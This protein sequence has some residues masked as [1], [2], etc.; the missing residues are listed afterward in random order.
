MSS[1]TMSLFLLL[2]SANSFLVSRSFVLNPSTTGS[3]I[4]IGHA[5]P[6]TSTASITNYMLDNSLTRNIPQSP[7][8]LHATTEREARNETRNANNYDST[9]QKSKKKDF[10]EVSRL[11]FMLNQLKGNM[12][13]S[14]MRAGAA[15]RRVAMLQ[16]QIQDNLQAQGEGQA[17]T[18][19]GGDG[20]ANRATT[21]ATMSAEEKAQQEEMKKENEMFLNQVKS[22]KGTI[23][24]I[25]KAMENFKKETEQKMADMNTANEKERIEWKKQTDALQGELTTANDELKTARKES[26]HLGAEIKA[27]EMHMEIKEQELIEES[28]RKLEEAKSQAQKVQYSLEV[29]KELLKEKLVASKDRTDELLKDL[30]MTKID[31]TQELITV[32]TDAEKQ[33]EKAKKDLDIKAQDISVKKETIKMLVGE[34]QSIRKL[35]RVQR[36]LIKARVKSRI[37]RIMGKS[38]E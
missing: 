28:E 38:E 23:K 5:I 10:T 37:G 8:S 35:F 27:L 18:N 34:R 26:D 14:E 12:Q 24:Q 22:L 29:E 32:K 30:E 6:T 25:N 4:Q 2:L 3:K 20:D 7:L 11:R 36:Y 31:M 17:P 13:E 1:N 15:E 19:N 33:L 21:T 16:K 9:Q